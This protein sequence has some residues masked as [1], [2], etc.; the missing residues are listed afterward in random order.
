[1]AATIAETHELPRKTAEAVM[2]DLVTLMVRHLKKGRKLRLS[3]FGILEV[4][5]R[6]PRKGRNPRTGEEVKIKASKRV[7]FR[8]SKEL[9]DAL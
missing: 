5:K 3:G 6:A 9:K 4:K 8:A 1:M 2:G 7:A